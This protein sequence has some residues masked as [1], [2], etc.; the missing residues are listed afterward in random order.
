MYFN[1]YTWAFQLLY[2]SLVWKKKVKG[3]ELFLTFDDGPVPDATEF[4]LEELDKWNV[5]ATFFCVGDNVRKYPHLLKEIIKRGHIAGNHTFNHLNGWRNDNEEYFNNIESCQAA[6]DEVKREVGVDQGATK[7]LFRPPYG[8]IKSSQ[9][10]ELQKSYEIIMW[11]V[12]TGDYDQNLKEE[13]CLAKSIKYSTPGSIVIFHDSI[14]A[15]KNM[16]YVL[17]R[18]IEYFLSKGFE[19]K[20]L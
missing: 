8:K 13:E 7:D 10:K 3:N 19:F 12:L 6:I 14:K 5:K 16:K 2:P 11:N 4:V 15:S 18:Y 9:S 17:P 1:N 20:T